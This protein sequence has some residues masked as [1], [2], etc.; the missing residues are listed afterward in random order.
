MISPGPFLFGGKMR[1]IKTYRGKIKAINEKEHKV[2]V[3]VSDASLDRDEE[4]ILPS[5]W[6]SRLD[7]YKSHPVLLSSH[8]YR[9]LRRQL[10]R[11]TD[12]LVTEEGLTCEFEYFVGEGN[13]EADWGWKL[14]E[15]GIA[16]YSVGFIRHKAVSKY[17]SDYEETLRQLVEQGILQA[18][19]TPRRIYLDVELLEVSQ[20]LVP[21]NPNA[22][23]RA[24][25]GD[26]PIACEIAKKIKED[27]M[28]KQS[29]WRAIPYSRHGDV[30]K[31]DE[32]TRWDGPAE[33]APADVEDL[34]MMC[35]FEDKNNLDIK[36][37]YKG[38]HHHH[39]KP[40][41]VVWNGVRAAMAALLGARGGFADI[42]EAERKSAYNHLVKHYQ[43]FEKE[44]PEYKQY[45]E[46]ELKAMFPDIYGKQVSLEDLEK[47]IRQVDEKLDAK[48]QI[49]SEVR[50]INKK[51]DEA[52]SLLHD[53]SAMQADANAGQERSY[54]DLIFRE[55][56]DQNKKL[57]EVIRDGQG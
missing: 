6:Q 42:P 21:A 18:G 20:V 12:I 52:I 53:L 19:Q 47:L 33:V 57:R 9:D 3:V 16:A 31:A 5:A 49:A 8:D 11:A 29:A 32:D 44:P 7:S 30:P 45:S 55:I 38:P 39:Q 28:E 25:C 14:V 10:G 15:K 13:E 54:I 37:G 41:R 36:S 35:L 22:I 2:T 23:Q 27:I 46:E 17:D 34:K 51:L 26:D 40:Y 24:L 43:Q 50:Q 4:I 56:E 48:L 1:Q